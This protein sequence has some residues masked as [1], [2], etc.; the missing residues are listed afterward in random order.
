MVPLEVGKSLSSFLNALITAKLPGNKLQWFENG[1]PHQ[2]SFVLED[3]NPTA[4]SLGSLRRQSGPNRRAHLVQSAASRF[5]DACQVIVHGLRSGGG[6]CGRRAGVGI[7]SF[8]GYCHKGVRFESTAQ[9]GTVLSVFRGSFRRQRPRFK[10][11]NVG[12]PHEML[13]AIV[14]RADL[15]HELRSCDRP[16]VRSSAA[17]PQFAFILFQQPEAWRCFLH[18]PRSTGATEPTHRKAQ[19]AQ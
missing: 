17:S 18:R 5:R 3:R 1:V 8:H 6:F 4:D 15:Q 13:R 11:R 12:H 19:S 2:R 7:W 10:K 14:F 16:V 9:T